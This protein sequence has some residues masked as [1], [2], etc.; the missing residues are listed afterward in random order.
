MY[1][2]Y[3]ADEPAAYLYVKR[4]RN[5]D[6]LRIV[7]HHAA[8]LLADLSMRSAAVNLHRI[9]IAYHS[10][11]Y[12]NHSLTQEQTLDEVWIQWNGEL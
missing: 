5:T 7:V 9:F 3:L 1:P 8:C 6:D 4:V 12:T 2:L 10:P 11:D